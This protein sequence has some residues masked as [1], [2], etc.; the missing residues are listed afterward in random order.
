MNNQTSHNSSSVGVVVIGRNE[1]DRLKRCLESL[2][3]T[4]DLMVYVDSG[5]TD[6]S[7]GFARLLGVN[8]WELD[9][10]KPFT[11]ARGRNE[12]FERLLQIK[13]DLDYVQFIDGDCEVVLG[14]I[15][16]ARETLDENEKFV[17]VAGL[18]KERYPQA[19]LY[20]QL[21]DIEWN[22]ACGIVPSTGGDVMIRTEPFEKSGGFNEG[23]IAGE[24]GELM[25]RLRREG[26]QVY[27]LDQTM[28]LH[29]A[30]MTR[31]SQWYK[32]TLRAGHAY[33]QGMSM[34]WLSCEKYNVKPVISSLAWGLGMPAL[35]ICCLIAALFWLPALIGVAMV[36]LMTIVTWARIVRCRWITSRN[37]PQSILFS[38]F[39][40]L[41]KLPQAMG[42]AWFVSNQLRGR[43]SGL[44]EYKTATTEVS[45]KTS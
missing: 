22:G 27:R 20:N 39:C 37:M 15:D 30:A 42:V 21:C 23:M 24:E 1:G 7:V 32:R 26:W 41:A 33:A 18:R 44:I 2:V 8:V 12:G 34:H 4:V 5:S 13:S 28:T 31:L 9:L 3:G 11:M 16:L 40:L 38:T 19:S 17:A 43:R 14:W 35:A 45:P 25:L 10:S 6:D 36:L 29:D